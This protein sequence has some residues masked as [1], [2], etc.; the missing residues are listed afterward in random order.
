MNIENNNRSIVAIANT[1]EKHRSRER[2][3]GLVREAVDLL[4]SIEKFVKPGN[5]VLIKP[6]LT[7]FYGAEEG[8]TTDPQV[9]GALIILRRKQAQERLLLVSRAASFS[10]PS[11]V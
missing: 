2:V 9:V 3:L 5:T 8:C 4:S 11:N 6:N 7:V 1:K 10:R